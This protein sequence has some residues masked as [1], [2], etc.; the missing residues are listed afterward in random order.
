MGLSEDTFSPG[1]FTT[2]AA[3]R[4]AILRVLGPLDGRTTPDL[5]E[6]MERLA[7]TGRRFVLCDLRHAPYADSDA[8]RFLADLQRRLHDRGGQLTLIL[9]D[10]SVIARALRLLGWEQLLPWYSSARRAWQLGA[11]RAA[12]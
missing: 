6:E 3:G 2:I 9:P 12:A 1:A 7:A 8:L 5:R 10:R 11:R 4:V